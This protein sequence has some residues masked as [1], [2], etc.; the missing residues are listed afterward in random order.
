MWLIYVFI[1]AALVAL[2]VSIGSFVVRMDERR[3]LEK[4]LRQF[5]KA[6]Y[7]DLN[8]HFDKRFEES[9]KETVQEINE[10]ESRYKL[11][12]VEDEEDLPKFGD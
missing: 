7:Y 3:Q 1:G 2:G 11:H 10:R 6:F 5:E 9:I 8:R 4:H 12:I